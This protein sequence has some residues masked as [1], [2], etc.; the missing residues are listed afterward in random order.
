MAARHKNQKTTSEASNQI[1][2][3]N[4][5][6]NME[7]GQHLEEIGDSKFT[8]KDVEAMISPPTYIESTDHS[9]A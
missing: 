7:N 8:S 9:S 2:T 5:I 3:L 6:N 4:E 1:Q